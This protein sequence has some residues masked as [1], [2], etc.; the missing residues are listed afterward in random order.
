MSTLTPAAFVLAV[1]LVGV[2]PMTATTATERTSVATPAQ[3]YASTPSGS[4]IE[5]AIWVVVAVMGLTVLIV[6]RRK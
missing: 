3:R 5:I 1:S 4:R 6:D 2:G